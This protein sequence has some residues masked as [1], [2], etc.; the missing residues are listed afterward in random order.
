MSLLHT[1]Q[2]S[3]LHLVLILINNFISTILEFHFETRFEHIGQLKD[4]EEAIT[5]QRI[6]VKL[7]FDTHINKLF[8]L[9]NLGV[10]LQ[11]RFERLGLL[12]DIE[13]AITV[14]YTAVELTS[15]SHNDKPLFLHNLGILL[16]MRFEHIGELKNIEEAIT[17]QH[18]A[19][20]LTFDT[21]VNKPLFLNNLGISLQ[22]RFECLGLLSDIE[23]AITAYRRAV[24]LIPDT[25]AVKPFYLH[26]FGNSL[27]IRFE[28]IGEL[29]DIEEAITIQYKAINLLSDSH[30]SMPVFLKDLV[31]SLQTS[32]RGKNR[33]LIQYADLPV[34]IEKAIITHRKALELIPDSCSNQLIYLD[35]LASLLWS[36]SLFSDGFDEEEELI[37]TYRKIVKLTP[38]RYLQ[39]SICFY[40]LGCNLY[41]RFKR[42]GKVNDIA[43]AIIM[44]RKAVEL[45]SNNHPNR[46]M[47][48]NYL[49]ESLLAASVND[50]EGLQQALAIYTQAAFTNTG[51]SFMALRAA[52]SALDIYKQ[53]SILIV[54][55]DMLNLYTRI[56]ELVPRIAWLGLNISRR[57]EVITQISD[58]VGDAV[59][60]AISTSNISLTVEW[61]EEGRAI[62]WTQI[63]NL[64]TPLDK[65]RAADHHN[66]RNL[67]HDAYL[68]V[69]ERKTTWIALKHFGASEE[70]PRKG[71]L[72]D[73]DCIVQPILNLITEHL[74]L[75]SAQEAHQLPHVTW[76]TTEYL[77]F[78]PLHAAGD[79]ITAGGVKA[80]DIV[81]SSYTPTLT[82]LIRP[83][84]IP[85][86]TPSILIVSQPDTPGQYPLP[87]TT[88]EANVI[89]QLFDPSS[90]QILHSKQGTKKAVLDAIQR[91]TW[92]HLA[93]HGKQ[94]TKD[95]SN[96]ALYLYDGKLT[97]ESL[98]SSSL[99]N[100]E[101]AFLSACETARGDKDTPNEAV[102]LAAGMLAAGYRSVVAT[103]WPIADKDG[104]KVAKVFYETLLAER[105][106]GRNLDVAY[107]LHVAV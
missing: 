70:I 107:A 86:S 57:Y 98:M 43:E 72:L 5:T 87:E 24:E 45:I 83:D 34:I 12:N 37:I 66:A 10:S 1:V 93:C 85:V 50:I 21:H 69:E 47:Y 101:L 104:P 102:H 71:V 11:I 74:N 4:I 23:E 19:V 25:H 96:S 29:N 82:N 52:M 55:S 13:D 16:R 53:N 68:S 42:V 46:V 6:A 49:G 76:C 59:A 64:R 35:Q 33:S 90:S 100:A 77:S 56:F 44:Y 67:R 60:Y 80:S 62:I 2:L 39:K 94:D 38:D 99:K 75:Q 36:R 14:H 73:W 78:L 84:S 88:E 54:H 32:F 97:L 20:K 63:L 22:I 81:I 41:T 91:H 7:T 95:P 17:A 92:V 18:T 58:A 40:N 79:Y 27:R 3:N 26:Y 15:D 30:V 61:F 105:K 51:S 8:F 9:N 106:V 31:Y 89:Q 103:M 28:H 65:L 48:L